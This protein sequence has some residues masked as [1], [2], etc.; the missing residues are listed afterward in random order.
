M[1]GNRGCRTAK[2]ARLEESQGNRGLDSEQSSGEQ[3]RRRILQPDKRTHKVL[4]NFNSLDQTCCEIHR[5]EQQ[6]GED[7]N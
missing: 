2:H 4:A 1:V 7:K 5:V 6:M 3:I